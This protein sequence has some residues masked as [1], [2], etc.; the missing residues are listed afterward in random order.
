MKST[1]Y[2]RLTWAVNSLGEMQGK[3]FQLTWGGD[4]LSMLAGDAGKAMTSIYDVCVM[5]QKDSRTKVVSI[6]P[7]IDAHWPRG[8]WEDDKM[9]F[10]ITE[11]SQL[12]LYDP[13]TREVTE[14]GFQL[15]RTW[16]QCWVF[17]YKESLVP[18]TRGNDNLGQ[19]NAVKKIDH[20]FNIDYEEDPAL[21]VVT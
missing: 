16:G 11:T 3:L 2:A 5:K 15:D 9:I 1:A 4:L 10:K 6:Q 19:D 20:F 8:I 12:V 21:L 7:L 14:L 18:I 17:N 13:T